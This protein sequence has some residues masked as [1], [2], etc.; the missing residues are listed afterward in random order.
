[1][2]DNFNDRFTG[3]DVLPSLYTPTR[4][5][6]DQPNS[7]YFRDPV[8]LRTPPVGD[9]LPIPPAHLRMGYG[10]PSDELFLNAGEASAAALRSLMKEHGIALNK[11]ASVL[12]WGCATGRVLRWFV[13]EAQEVEFWG[14]DQDESSIL[15]AKE[16][17]SPP[18]Q[19]VTGSAYPH[20]PFPDNKF[21]LVY[22]LSVFTHLEHFSDLWL[23]EIHRVM[24]R[25]GYAIFTIH[26]ENTVRHFLEH[27]R[28]SWIP[29]EL[30]LSEIVEHETTIIHGELWHQ[31]YTFHLGE[32]ILREWGRYFRILGLRAK[33]EGYQS[34]V[35]LRKE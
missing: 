21:G 17:L 3:A 8:K 26:D 32:Y 13:Q 5:I 16:N 34:A 22:G 20:L 11:T 25:G 2:H 31:T 18:F 7:Y 10:V 29:T 35:V 15:W 4:R 23:L 24:Q 12:D 27:G 28:P 33:S 9:Q 19:F 14:V 1:M 6:Q 30:A